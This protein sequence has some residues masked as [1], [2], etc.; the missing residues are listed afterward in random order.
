[1]ARGIVVTAVNPALVTTETF[2]HRDM[3]QRRPGMV[4]QPERV[5]ET[6]VRVVRKGKGPE[7]SIPRWLASF[8]AVRVL[9]P[10]LYRFGLTRAV[11][12]GL[13]ATRAG[14]Q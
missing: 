7:V 6:I 11:R 10:A 13:R 3:L 4:M 14:E 8:Q 2:P 5:G 12:R 9:A 1:M